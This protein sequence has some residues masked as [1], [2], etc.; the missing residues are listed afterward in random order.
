ME[1]DKDMER[2]NIPEEDTPPW[3][4]VQE[5]TFPRIMQGCLDKKLLKKFGITQHVIRE[6]DFLFFIDFC[7]R[8]VTHPFPESGRTNGLCIIMR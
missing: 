2:E 6:R 4:D 8:C 3:S 1:L 7:G 5:K